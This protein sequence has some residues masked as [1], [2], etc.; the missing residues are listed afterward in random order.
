[1][2]IFNGNAQAA[3]RKETLKEKL[4]KLPQL[5]LFALVF[6]EDEPSIMYTKLKKK[7]AEELGILYT[8]MVLPIATPLKNIGDVLSAASDDPSI[9]GIIVQK[10]MKRMM[11]SPEWWSAVVSTIPAEKDVDGLTEHT[12]VLPAT[13]RAILE[14]VRIAEKGTG[15]KLQEMNTI[16]LGRSQIV[17]L[18]VHRELQKTAKHAVMF[19]STENPEDVDQ[20]LKAADLVVSATGWEHSVIATQLKKE[21]ICIDAGSPKPEIDPAGLDYVAAFLSPVPG[22]VG[23]M[24]R[25]C[26]LENLV[27]LVQ[28]HR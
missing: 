7:D 9:H 28:S 22:G 1:M 23:P 19:G 13:A 14:V 18:P 11:P 16:V 26:L 15:R 3:R 8:Y 17:G 4:K 24:T 27:D 20:A 5:H 25:V 12:R 2:I 6:Q 21:V 10:P